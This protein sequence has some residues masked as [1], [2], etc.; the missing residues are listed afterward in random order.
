MCSKINAGEATE[1]QK[2]AYDPSG[3]GEQHTKKGRGGCRIHCVIGR[4]AEH[5]PASGQ[6]IDV[7]KT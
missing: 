6:F 2:G 5:G 1:Y 7:Q 4:Q 3:R